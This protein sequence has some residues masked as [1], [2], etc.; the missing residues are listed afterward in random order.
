MLSSQKILMEKL[1]ELAI[2]LGDDDAFK[3]KAL[4]FSDR[5]DQGPADT[6]STCTRALK[7]EADAAFNLLL[8]ELDFLKSHQPQKIIDKKDEEEDGGGPENNYPTP[9]PNFF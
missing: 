4:T 8:A 2:L 5:S 7:N 6:L 1:D 3:E 9:G